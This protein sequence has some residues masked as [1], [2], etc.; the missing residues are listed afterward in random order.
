[1]KHQQIFDDRRVSLV[2][3]VEP[4]SNAFDDLQPFLSGLLKILGNIQEGQI[5]DVHADPLYD[6]DL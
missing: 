1:M 6:S 5:Y 3:I 4:A 2:Q